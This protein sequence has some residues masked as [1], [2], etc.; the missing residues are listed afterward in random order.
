MDVLPRNTYRWAVV[1]R[2]LFLAYHFPPLGLSGVQRTVKFV[3]YLPEF[4]WEAK[5]LTGPGDASVPGL[6]FDS[7]LATEIPGDLEVVRCPGP[8]PPPSMGNRARLERWLMLDRPWRRWWVESAYD[9]AV[10]HAADADVI[11]ASMSPF[12]SAEA[13]AK[14]SAA[15]GTPWI[16]DLRD[17]WALDEMLVYAT[18]LHRRREIARM[19]KGLS[20]AAAIVMNTPEAARAVRD[21]FPEFADRPVFSI[22]NGYDATDF[23]DA[24]PELAPDLFRI[25]HTGSF[26]T[27]AGLRRRTML[28]RRLLGGSVGDVDF[29]TRSHL[30][31]VEAVRLLL[32]ENPSLRGRIR[33]ALAGVMTAKDRESCTIPGI[34][35]LGY[36]D[37]AESVATLRSAD[38]L[39]LPMHKLSPGRRARIVPGKTY[40]YLASRRP[41]LAAVPEGDARDLLAETPT[42]LVCDP[43]DV[44]AMAAIIKEQI[45]RKEAGDPAPEPPEELLARFE[46]RTLT[47]RLAAVLD[48]VTPQR[49]RRNQKLPG[50]ARSTS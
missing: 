29:L 15:T 36:L 8:E 24:R 40:E 16:A 28:A 5:V 21:A 20:S 12:E 17:P 26:H 31:L 42:G 13:A 46:R 47:E 7:T 45:R 2:C 4:G 37:H 38:L 14:L 33:L 48:E 9:A 44:T 50:L 11:V 34:E 25:A 43:D 22:T 27:A 3:R 32:E 49:T 10:E 19:R 1:P 41:I 18:R 35:E 30:Y 23:V 6:P 39:F